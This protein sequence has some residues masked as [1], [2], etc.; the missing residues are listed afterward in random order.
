M[1]QIDVEGD[2]EIAWEPGEQE[3][4]DVVVGAEAEDHA[5]DFGL[6]EEIAEGCL[7]RLLVRL[8]RVVFGDVVA[9]GF[10]EFGVVCGIAVD[11]PEEEEV[12]EAE[13]AGCG[14]APAPADSE[15]QHA[16]EWDSDGGGELGGGVEE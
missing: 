4:E 6:P 8:R 14:E 12:E 2:G 10:G 9:L 11:L 1:Q 7:F 13:N 16:D 3:V 5:D 15:E